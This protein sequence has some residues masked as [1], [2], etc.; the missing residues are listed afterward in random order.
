MFGAILLLVI[1]LCYKIRSLAL[2]NNDADMFFMLAEETK[3][4]QDE[5]DRKRPSSPD[6]R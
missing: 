5:P 1:M 6:S 4:R 3:Q 2:K